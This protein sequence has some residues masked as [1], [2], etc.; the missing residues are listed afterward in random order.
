VCLAVAGFAGCSGWDPRS[1]F[2][3]NAPEVDEAIRA[4]DA[5]KPEPAAEALE[6]YL[7]TGPCSADGG[8][9]LPPSVRQKA[10][11][12]FDLGLT[13]FYLSERFG[14]RF[15]E[16]EQGD[17]GA[18]EEELAAR[19]SAEID[20]ALLVV[21]AIAAD[22]KVPTELRARA[23]YLA[24]NLE[25]MRRKNED[26]IKEYD[27]ALALVPGMAEDSGA[28]GLGRDAAWNRAVAQRR[29]ADQKDAGNDAPDADADDGNDGSDGSDAADGSDGHDGA[30]GSDGHDG[31]D[32]GDGGNDGDAG[33]D[34]GN[35]GGKDDAGKDGGDQQDGG[36][37][38]E[39]Q[40]PQPASPEKQQDGR[41]LDQLEQTP[42]YQAQEAKKRAGQRR[43]RPTM[44]D[45]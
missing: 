17:G 39:K 26:A 27:Q 33:K 35:D 25:L 1:P 41:M 29:A 5:G 21:R 2:E 43:G 23:H 38:P 22:P 14:R 10:N 19:R 4:L 9:A 40:P 18:K 20:C 42:S 6:K 31:N 30:D 45:K 3:R 7:D 24:G 32:G 16:E 12:S 37:Q 15:G 8:I 28:D 34:G 44:E 36:Q 11:G 13:L